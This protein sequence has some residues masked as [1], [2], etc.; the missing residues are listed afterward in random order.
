MSAWNWK[1]AMQQRY[2]NLLGWVSKGNVNWK[3][4]VSFYSHSVAVH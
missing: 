3:S 2:R 1:E 4:H